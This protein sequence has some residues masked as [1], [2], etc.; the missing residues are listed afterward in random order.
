MG[1]ADK[2]KRQ[3]WLAEQLSK[4]PA[5]ISNLCKGEKTPTITTLPLLA[6]VFNVKVSTFIAW[7]EE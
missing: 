1:L 4:S 7:G 3:K 5:Y 2:N 6:S